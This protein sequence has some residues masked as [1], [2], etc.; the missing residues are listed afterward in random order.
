MWS[1]SPPSL[2]RGS[3]NFIITP[4]SPGPEARRRDTSSGA[5]RDRHQV[6]MRW[7]CRVPGREGRPWWLQ[8][9]GNK[10]GEPAHTVSSREWSCESGGK[11]SQPWVVDNQTR[12]RKPTDTDPWYNKESLGPHTRLHFSKYS[13]GSLGSSYFPLL[14]LSFNVQ[15]PF[16]P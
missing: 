8:R 1:P 7:Q 13:V 6:G 10:R 14:L 16:A 5:C 15:Q 11:D 12:L 9:Q 2:R 3:Q 4:S